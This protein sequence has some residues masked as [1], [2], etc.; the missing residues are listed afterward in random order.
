M[1]D[2]ASGS[3]AQI[4]PLDALTLDSA[5][6][7]AIG[8][9]MVELS[10]TGDGAMRRAFG[11]DT[12]NTAL[13]L[14]RLGAG[15]RYVTAL[16][17]DPYSDEMVAG[18]QS[19][20]IDTD[21][22]FRDPGRVP[23]LYVIRTDPSGERQFL[24]WRSEAPARTLFNADRADRTAAKL[25]AADIVYLSGISLALYGAEGRERLFAALNAAKANNT[26]IVFDANYRP[27]NWA[28]ADEAAAAFARMEPLVDVALTG[29]DDETLLTGKKAEPEALADR[30]WAAGAREIAI[31]MGADG[32]LVRDADGLTEVP[33][34]QVDPVVDTTAAGDSF[35]AGYLAARL[36]GQPPAAAAAAGGKLAAIVIGHRGAI[37][38]IDAMKTPSVILNTG[39]QP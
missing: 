1:T 15:V 36:A 6:I 23:G 22:V 10:D 38:P 16:G 28:S 3:D 39:E 33:P 11:G 13:Y 37:I 26:R 21:D 7:A 31:K 34:L 17:D 29:I 32:A 27:K 14:V 4:R 12:L 24:Y 8:E 18:W 2:N 9:C 35:N 30:L 5:R 19:E 25:A 20:G